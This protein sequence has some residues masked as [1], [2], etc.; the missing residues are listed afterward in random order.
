M[1]KLKKYQPLL[2]NEYVDPSKL[3]SMGFKILDKANIG[4]YELV[5]VEAKGKMRKMLEESNLPIYQIGMDKKETDFT[6]LESHSQKITK[7]S[8]MAFKNIEKE[9]R[10]YLVKWLQ[11]YD[12]IAI[13][14][15]SDKKT[16]FYAKMFDNMMIDY[17]VVPDNPFNMDILVI[18]ML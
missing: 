12:E 4:E 18:S 14:S 5:L 6:D 17:A 16:K 7:P 3:K 1:N 8:S 11:K 15:H 9:M 13:S 10:R 2:L